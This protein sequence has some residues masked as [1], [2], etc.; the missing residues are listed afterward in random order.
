MVSDNSKN[1]YQ[2]F[3]AYTLGQLKDYLTARGLSCRGIKKH[4]E[5]SGFG[6]TRKDFFPILMREIQQKYFNP[7]KEWSKD[8]EVI[9]KIFGKY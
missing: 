5:S 1:V 6:W 9:G 2:E 4:L 8:Y 3:A 7:V